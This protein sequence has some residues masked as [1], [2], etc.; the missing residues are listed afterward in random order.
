MIVEFLAAAF[1]G[2]LDF[3]MELLPVASDLGLT[4]FSGVWTGY[5]FLNGWL[6]LTETLAAVGIFLGAHVLL[7]A[8]MGVLALWRLVPFKFS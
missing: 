6:P 7:Y 5:A 1:L 3:V 2:V 8:A 4:E